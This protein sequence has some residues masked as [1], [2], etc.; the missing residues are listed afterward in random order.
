MD[1]VLPS[2][3]FSNSLQEQLQPP[4]SCSSEPVRFTDTVLS[5]EALKGTYQFLHFHQLYILLV[6]LLVLDLQHSFQALQLLLQIHDL[7]VFLGETWQNIAL[8]DP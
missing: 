8:T 4:H 6:Q 1:P 2:V 7:R 3:K 5:G